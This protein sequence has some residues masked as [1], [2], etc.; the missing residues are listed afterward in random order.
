MWTKRPHKPQ[1]P[2]L[3]GKQQ[4]ARA[5]IKDLIKEDEELSE[6]PMNRAPNDA[7]DK[8]TYTQEGEEDLK[9]NSC[10]N[11]EDYPNMNGMIKNTK[12]TSSALSMKN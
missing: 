4:V 10:D 9:N 12:W 6:T 1:C 7:L 3:K 11:D 2:K 8:S 5:Q